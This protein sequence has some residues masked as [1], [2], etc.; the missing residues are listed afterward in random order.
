MVGKQIVN[1]SNLVEKMMNW[2]EELTYSNKKHNKLQRN[3]QLLDEKKKEINDKITD[4]RKAIE[5]RIEQFGNQ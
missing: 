1:S 4:L 2:E 5:I 3:M